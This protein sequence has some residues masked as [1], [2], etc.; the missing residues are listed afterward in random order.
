[1]ATCEISSVYCKWPPHAWLLASVTAAS[2]PCEVYTSWAL[3]MDSPSLKF[4]PTRKLV[5][6]VCRTVPCPSFLC[7]GR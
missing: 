5:T 1:M 3:A 2:C 6:V 7:A 4:Q